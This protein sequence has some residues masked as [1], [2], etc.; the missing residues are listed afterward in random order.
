M[1]YAGD[2]LFNGLRNVEGLV[3][4]RIFPIIAP[5]KTPAPFIVY[6]RVSGRGEYTK[7]LLAYDET[8]IELTVVTATYEEGRTRAKKLRDIIEKERLVYATSIL[9][10]AE[11][12]DSS[13]DFDGEEYSQR[14]VFKCKVR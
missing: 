3:G 4:D 7:D 8:N 11:V 12:V 9:Y 2:I 1:I 5:E 14:L 10:S 6:R 13:E